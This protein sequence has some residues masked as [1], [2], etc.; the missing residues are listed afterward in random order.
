ML[1]HIYGYKHVQKI[2]IDIFGMRSNGILSTL[3]P[4]SRLWEIC[5]KFF[6]PA[7][8]LMH[9]LFTTIRQDPKVED[10]SRRDEF[11]SWALVCS[12]DTFI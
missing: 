9:V 8:G 12:E 10:Y 7:V 11:P 4:H 6:V 3:G 2:A 5:W 1:M